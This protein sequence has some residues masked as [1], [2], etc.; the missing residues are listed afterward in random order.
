MCSIPSAQLGNVL[1]LSNTFL[2]G[3]QSDDEAVSNGS[4]KGHTKM[5]SL[6][7]SSADNISSKGFC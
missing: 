6:D 4:R 2:S 5:V 7:E 1:F 3:F